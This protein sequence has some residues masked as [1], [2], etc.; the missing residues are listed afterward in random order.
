MHTAFVCGSAVFRN[1]G[2]TEIADFKIES[3]NKYRD[4]D[5]NKENTDLKLWKDKFGF[6]LYCE[7]C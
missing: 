2:Y 3:L 1:P 7:I 6:G 5:Q 4:P